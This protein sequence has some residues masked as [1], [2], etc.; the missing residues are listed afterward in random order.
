MVKTED[1]TGA[2]G[3]VI[4]SALID[5]DC[6]PR[7]ISSCA[8]ND[9]EGEYRTILAAI[10]TLTIRGKP[11]DPVTVLSV[12]GAA[13]EPTIRRLIDETPTAENVG[14]YMDICKEQ[15][16]LARLTTLGAELTGA[17]TLEDAREILQR[18]QTVSVEQNAARIVD[19]S[20]ALAGFYDQHQAGKHDYIS[21]GF[22]ALDEKLAVDPGD[23]LVIGGYPSDGKTALMLQWAWKISDRLPVG[24]FSFETSADKLTDRLVTQAVS[25]LS[26]TD[27]KRSTMDAAAWKE[28]TAASIEI[29]RK[30]I[31]IVEAAG[32]TADDILGLSL[33]RGFGCICIDYVQL[34]SPGSVRRGGTR[35]EEVAEISKALA[36]MA[37]RHRLLVIELS[38]LSRPQK[39]AK[40]KTPAPTLSSLRESG[41][42]EQD[43]DVV[44]LLYRTS[45][46]E[47][48]R[49]ELYVA[50]NKEGRTG[51]MELAFNGER[52]RFSYIAR[53]D[54]IP[55]ELAAAQKNRY[56]AKKSGDEQMA[57]KEA[58][59]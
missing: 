44:A 8:D 58:V 48:A 54:D 45:D 35:A 17:A 13:Y 19:M 2:Q 43:A 20:T 47:N 29:S 9:F 32:M 59:K 23:V 26:F 6:V 5:P 52:Q 38:Q 22:P 30:K 11:V 4:G 37:R 56:E 34:V 57:I 53:G 41:Q 25:K 42:L 18:M 14:A 3:A 40:G 31:E 10:R 55:R 46:A 16:R 27:V 21:V 7:I 36:L 1:W 12:I 15:S 24:I 51:R 33:S 39:T 49:R 28:I 50:K